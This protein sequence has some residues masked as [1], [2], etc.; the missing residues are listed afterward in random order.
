MN[1]Q[2]LPAQRTRPLADWWEASSAMAPKFFQ[3]ISNDNTG[4]LLKYIQF[5]NLASHFP[6][7][8]EE[9]EFMSQ[10]IKDLAIHLCWNLF[11]FEKLRFVV[12]L[13][14]TQFAIFLFTWL[15]NLTLRFTQKSSTFDSVLRPLPRLRPWTHWRLPYSKPHKTA[16]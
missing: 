4:T 10:V 14:A 9:A 6:E 7:R 2:Y 15:Q 1:L 3:R 11:I 12:T 16:P 8:E 5:Q 13:H